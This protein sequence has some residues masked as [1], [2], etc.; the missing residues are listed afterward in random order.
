M[1][2]IDGRREVMEHGPREMPVWGAV[3]A[4][5]VG[6]ERW[7]F[8]TAMLH[9]RALTDYLRSLQRPREASDDPAATR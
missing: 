9:G 8:Y 7:G 5:Q 3:F 4:E 6:E 1:Q 2:V